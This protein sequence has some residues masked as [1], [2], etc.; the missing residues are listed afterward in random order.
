MA[1]SS[2]PESTKQKTYRV[3]EVTDEELQKLQLAGFRVQAIQRALMQLTDEE[4]QNLQLE[5]PRVE[6][7]APVRPSHHHHDD[8]GAR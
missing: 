7:L 6:P 1:E 3:V 8:E 4:L 2:Q 5:F